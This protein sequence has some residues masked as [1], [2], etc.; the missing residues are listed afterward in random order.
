MQNNKCEF[1]F[2][3]GLINLYEPIPVRIML[4]DVV[5][6]ELSLGATSN[7]INFIAETVGQQNYCLKFQVLKISKPSRIVINNLN[8][9]WPPI[10]GFKPAWRP[11]SP[12]EIW[13]YADADATKK[14]E[15][16]VRKTQNIDFDY[17]TSGRPAYLKKFGRFESV[18]GSV[19]TFNKL[20]RPFNIVEAGTFKIDFTSPI[21]YW[22]YQHMV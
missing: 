18:T 6:N 22:L 13:N 20:E 7:S 15:D 10:D 2:K 12:N 16:L 8:V 9:G 11:T 19:F 3:L 5:I 4:N 1:T 17:F 14:Q 21:A